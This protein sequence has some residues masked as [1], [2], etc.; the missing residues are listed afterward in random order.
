[1]SD[2]EEKGIMVREVIE[3]EHNDGKV[4]GETV[5]REW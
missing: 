1:M 2:N 5:K 4:V 3:R